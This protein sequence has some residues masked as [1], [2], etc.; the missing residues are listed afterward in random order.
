M[1]EG[2]REFK[3]AFVQAFANGKLSPESTLVAGELARRGVTV[4][5]K[6]TEET[7]QH[8]LPLTRDDLVVG[9]FDWT[10]SALSQLGIAMPQPPDYPACLA[11]LLHRRVWQSTLGEV[12]EG[13]ETVFIKPAVDTKAFS[14]LVASP[15]WLAYLLDQFP[16]SLAVQCSELVEMAAEWR[17]Y[18]VDGAVRASCRY[19]GDLPLDDAVVRHAVATLFASEEGRQLAGCAIDFA[20]IRKPDGTLVTGLVEVNDGYS[21]GAYEGLSAADYTDMLIARWAQLVA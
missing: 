5:K 12:E 2:R 21:L 20:V 4:V 10:R 7:L 14:G 16:R 15:D 11:Q 18:C 3:R 17:V 6:T 9:D 13:G 19:K 1:Q 8:P